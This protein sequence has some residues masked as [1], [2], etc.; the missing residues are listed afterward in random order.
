MGTGADVMNN[1]DNRKTAPIYVKVR[2][3][4]LEICANIYKIICN[5]NDETIGT[6]ADIMETL[7]NRKTVHTSPQASINLENSPRKV[8]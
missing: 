1:R 8:S 3:L 5:D 7:D 4:Y 6:R 2:L